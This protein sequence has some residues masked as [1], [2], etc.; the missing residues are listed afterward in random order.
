MG[1]RPTCQLFSDS[2]DNILVNLHVDSGEYNTHSFKI[3]T[4]TSAREAGVPDSTILKLSRWQSNAYLHYV[5]T[6]P[7]KLAQLSETSA[8]AG[9][10]LKNKLITA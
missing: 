2:L 6:T 3:D 1:K 9:N 8:T 5:K 4:A 10:N 7:D